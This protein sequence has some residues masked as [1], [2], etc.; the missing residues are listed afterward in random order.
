MSDQAKES[1]NNGKAGPGLLKL[2]ITAIVAIAI[3]ASLAVVTTRGVIPVQADSDGDGLLNEEE[4]KLGTDP[5]NPDTD[6]DGLT[7]GEEV[8]EYGT[9][10][11]EFDTD[12]DGLGDGEEVKTYGTNP[13]D[14]DTD[15]D[16][17]DDGT[18]VMSYGTDP[19]KNDTD[20]DGISDKDEI[21]RYRTDPKS[22]D[23]DGD[24]LTD[25]GE[26]RRGTDPLSQDTDGDGVKDSVDID[27]LGN[28]VLR[29]SIDY[30]EEK[31]YADSLIFIR[32]DPLFVI[33]VYDANGRQLD[34]VTLGEY[35]NVSTLSGIVTYID[36]P[37]S[38]T[39]FIITITVYDVDPGG[40]EVYDI[41]P[42]LGRES[43]VIHFNVLDGSLTM[44]FDGSWDGSSKD[45]DGLL[46][47]TVSLSRR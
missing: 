46:Q 45:L 23:T 7:D 42:E 16:G 41:S 13:K 31:E 29:V 12:S 8:E 40:Y 19:T 38:E 22:R 43:G 1:P 3:L 30:W 11:V 34:E 17:L 26:L 35:S 21:E 32:G 28:A 5:Q 33:K 39:E 47:V 20:S 25:G 44:V 9:S 6:N 27:P 24:G 18:E 2:T 15:N 4:E 10:P 36:I 37:D 14:K